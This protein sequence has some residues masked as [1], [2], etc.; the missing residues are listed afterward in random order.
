MK[1]QVLT[2]LKPAKELVIGDLILTNKSTVAEVEAA[3]TFGNSA[4]RP[5]VE[6]TLLQ[7]GRKSSVVFLA[8]ESVLTVE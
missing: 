3:E 1:K 2:Y 6:V 5:C 4:K 7:C 8:E